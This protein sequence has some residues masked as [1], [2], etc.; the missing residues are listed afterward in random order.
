MKELKTIL[1]A[2]D[3][4]VVAARAASRELAKSLGFG[5]ADQTRLATAVSELTR[6]ILRY[7]VKGECHIV[8]DSDDQVCGI[9]VVVEDRGPGI[10][11]LDQAMEDGYTTGGGLGAGL[12]GTKRLVHEFDIQSQPGLT[13]VSI[14]MIS[15]KRAERVGALRLVAGRSR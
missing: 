13:R 3:Q 9:K 12:P 6:N 2:K 5:A 1:I 4:D 10:P 15:R 11:S 14:R 8:D 7:A